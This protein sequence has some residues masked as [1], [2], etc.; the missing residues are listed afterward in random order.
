MIQAVG[1]IPGL[2]IS[3]GAFPGS[4]YPCIPLGT[5]RCGGC[6]GAQSVSE[7]GSGW[8]SPAGRDPATSVLPER[9]EL[10]KGC[11]LH[12]TPGKSVTVTHYLSLFSI[13]V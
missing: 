5:S 12:S 3:Q 9:E 6:P 7:L 4:H 13:V 2:S 10:L 11:H 8:Q 1:L